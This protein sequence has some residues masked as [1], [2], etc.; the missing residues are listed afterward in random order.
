MKINKITQNLQKF[1]KKVS[2]DEK[3]YNKVNNYIIPIGETIV[4]TGLYD[5]FIKHNKHLE[6]DRKPALRYQNAICGIAGIALSS[7]V[8][9]SISKHQEGI[10]NA[11]KKNKTLKNPE[12]FINGLK[13]AMPVVVFTSIIR[14]LIPVISTP[15]SAK[16]RE[17]RGNWYNSVTEK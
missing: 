16:I 2:Q 5:V 4:A 17:K 14:F 7:S 13:I 12:E 8:N 10:I 1:A 15:I 6:N 9:K 11:L 3:L